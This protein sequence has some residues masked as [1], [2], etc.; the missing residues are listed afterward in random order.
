MPQRSEKESREVI[1]S[2]EESERVRR[3]RSQKQLGFW[4]L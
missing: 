1:F 4:S 3:K 2:Q